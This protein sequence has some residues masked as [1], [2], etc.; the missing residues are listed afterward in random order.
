MI[1]L[2]YAP[3]SRFVD[4]ILDAAEADLLTDEM[5]EIDRKMLDFYNVI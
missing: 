2:E 4:L 5:H 1:T 3:H